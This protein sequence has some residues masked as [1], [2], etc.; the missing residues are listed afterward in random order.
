[1]TENPIDAREL[2]Q[3]VQAEKRAERWLPL[4]PADLAAVRSPIRQD[5]A[6]SALRDRSVLN[7][8]EPEPPG[9]GIKGFILRIF[10]RLTYRVL[11]PYLDD[12][13]RSIEAL[14]GRCDE[15]AQAIAGRQRDEAENGAKLAAWLHN[16]L[17]GSAGD[18]ESTPL[19]QS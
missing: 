8:R 18:S 11:A 14:A 13:A 17:P 5:P 7:R 19:V 2:L 16:E 12:Q 15:L 4:P 9:T 3:R 1:M 6:V 10:A